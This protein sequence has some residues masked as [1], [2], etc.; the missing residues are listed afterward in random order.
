MNTKHIFRFHPFPETPVIVKGA[1]SLFYENQTAYCPVF[2]VSSQ[3]LFLPTD[4]RWPAGAQVRISLRILEEIQSY[5]GIGRVVE[6]RGCP[7][8]ILGDGLL[9]EVQELKKVQ[10][11]LKERYLQLR[12]G[13]EIARNISFGAVRY[14][15]GEVKGNKVEREFGTPYAGFRRPVLLI[16]GLF[17]TRGV[18]AILENKLKRDGFPVFSFSLGHVNMADIT[19]S[20]QLAAAKLERPC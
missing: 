2:R 19:R 14:V 12:H 9:V 8:G 3:D 4:Q 10:L 18:F 7:Q 13:Q 17:G 20:A 15:M 16:Q 1:C 6:Y 5:E 11:G